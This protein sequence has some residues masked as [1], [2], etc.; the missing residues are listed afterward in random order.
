MNGMT[1]SP[2]NGK[3]VAPRPSPKNGKWPS[4]SPSPSPTPHH[5]HTSCSASSHHHAHHHI[6]TSQPSPISYQPTSFVTAGSTYLCTP[7]DTTIPPVIYPIPAEL[8]SQARLGPLS[9]GVG[10]HPGTARCCIQL[11]AFCSSDR[12]PCCR[13]AVAYTCTAFH[14]Y[15]AIVLPPFF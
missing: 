9:T 3:Y 10:D 1:P 5:T 13:A 15:T 6:I 2:K 12:S 7:L 11:F 4:P 8:G 14:V